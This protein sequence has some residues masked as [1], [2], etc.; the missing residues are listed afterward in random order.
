L[1]TQD[2]FI[3]DF[4]QE[5]Y[6]RFVNLA[7]SNYKFSFFH[8]FDKQSK[9]A[10]WRHDI[11]FSL[12]YSRQLAQI[13]AENGVHSTFFVLPHCRFY[14]ALE[15]RSKKIINEIREMGHEIGLH[16]DTHFYEIVEEKTLED[17]LTYERDFF[18]KMFNTQL[19]VF[20]FH[21][22]TDF[23][24][25]CRKWSYAGM[26][27]TYASYFQDE[28][29]YCSDSNGYWRFQRLENFLLENHNCIQVLTHPGWWQTKAKVPYERVKQVARENYDRV[30]DDYEKALNKFGRPNVK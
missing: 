26:I 22:T 3:E 24:M 21:A 19:K 4:T 20:S 25:S 1:N 18:S 13:E 29:K 2:F 28:V 7:K 15:P 9:F 16:F 30:M 8:D 10:L 6:A 12:D 14:N 11:D 27:N 17:A 23:T 5:N